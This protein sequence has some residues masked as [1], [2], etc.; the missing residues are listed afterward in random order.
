MRSLN[1]AVVL[2]DAAHAR[3]TAHKVKRALRSARGAFRMFARA[4]TEATRRRDRN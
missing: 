4:A 3:G 2:A 1:A